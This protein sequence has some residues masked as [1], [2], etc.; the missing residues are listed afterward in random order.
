MNRS[1]K[2][3]FALLA[4]LVI[5]AAALLGGAALLARTGDGGRVVLFVS[6]DTRGYLE[7]CGCRRDQAGGLP[8]RM[9]LIKQ[10]QTPNRLLVDVGNLTSGG[11]S[12]ELLKVHYL[13]AGMERMRYDAANLGEREA[14]LDR[15][16]LAKLIS[17]SRLPLVS[18]N[19]LNQDTGRPIAPA[20]IITTAA[21]LRIGITGVAEANEDQIGPG[22][23]VRPAAEALA[24]TLPDLKQRADFI[25]VL[26][27]A[28]QDTLRALAD[29]FHEI[30]CLLGGNVAQSSESAER[31]NRAVAFNVTGKG[32]AL[33]RLAFARKG[34]TLELAGSQA[35]KVKDTIPPAP[36]MA[37]IIAEF[38]E[39]LRQRS[40]E[41]ASEEGL[42][43]IGRSQTT[44]DLYV[45]QQECAGCH[46]NAH[47]IN[48]SA[49]HTRAYER[50]TAK[51]A[52]FDPECLHCHTVGFGAK[53]GFTTLQRTPIMAGVQC[54]N[55][56]G[57]GGDH[58]KAKRA[59]LNTQSTFRP[60]TP[61]TCVK[62][63]DKENSE[64]FDYKTYWPKIAHGKR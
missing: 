27:Y 50:L 21:G 43:P 13:L 57:R 38:R 9:T 5:S 53:D 52:E 7:P 36:E 47:A 44:A 63:H 12:Y 30:D 45:G 17:E 11:R 46:Q 26:A 59:K 58:V 33:G 4:I 42:D 18:C 35:L 1:A 54:E 14:G 16:T 40:I 39:S 25:I 28:R 51:R 32:K 37:S 49:A 64:N 55:C 3:S 62:C 22:L 24:E 6:G 34:S 23:R 31:L 19:I 20:T 15:D 48:F 2:I 8:A 10:D 61:N 56:H 29:R 60:V 41:L